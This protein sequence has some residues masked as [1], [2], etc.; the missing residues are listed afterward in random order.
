MPMLVVMATPRTTRPPAQVL[1]PRCVSDSQQNNKI[2]Q[3]E[4]RTSR[5]RF[6][7]HRFAGRLDL[8]TSHRRRRR[9]TLS[10]LVVYLLLLYD[11]ISVTQC[12]SG[13]YSITNNHYQA[14]RPGSRPAS[15]LDSNKVFSCSW[16]SN[17]T[18]HNSP[19]LFSF[20]SGES[21]PPLAAD[22][23]APP[24][25]R[26]D[27]PSAAGPSRPGSRSSLELR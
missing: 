21:R 22:W 20:F 7:F 26:S 12:V 17:N 19:G 8:Q 16:R 5:L 24:A 11:F 23:P 3:S 9:H 25:P 13:M 27:W 6:Y 1:S 2:P 14:W 10:T 18:W 4:H 15:M